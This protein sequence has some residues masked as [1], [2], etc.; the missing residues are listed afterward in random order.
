MRII[1]ADNLLEQTVE[2]EAEAL[3]QVAK[4]YTSGDIEEWRSWSAALA[5]RTAFKHDIMDAPTVDA[6]PIR[7]GR[8]SRSYCPNCGAK[9][10]EDC[11]GDEKQ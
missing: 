11:K 4:Y 7:H 6:E 1:D 10:D 8:W 3:E 2:L 9:M 5:E